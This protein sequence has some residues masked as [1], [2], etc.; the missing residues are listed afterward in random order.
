M[1]AAA[2]RFHGRLARTLVLGAALLAVLRTQILQLVGAGPPGRLG[3]RVSV[4][5]LVLRSS[6]PFSLARL[7]L[8]RLRSLLP[9]SLLQSRLLSMHSALRRTRLLP[10][11]PLQPSLFRLPKLPVASR[12]P[13][14]SELA[15]MLRTQQ[16]NELKSERSRSRAQ[17]SVCSL[18]R[19]PL[20]AAPTELCTR[21]FA[22][23]VRP[24]TPSPPPSLHPATHRTA[25]RPH[26]AHCL[27]SVFAAL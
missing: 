6:S 24:T 26:G 17:R 5:R 14:Q 11:R 18:A 20:A 15:S 25:P 1:P 4:T 3:V 23:S 13:D 10:L 2:R 27:L 7:A 21:A 22:F 19:A 8:S 16:H 9:S 12:K